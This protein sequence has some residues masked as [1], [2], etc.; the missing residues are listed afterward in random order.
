[1]GKTRAVPRREI[2]I[3]WFSPS[4]GIVQVV[5]PK[6]L[7]GG[8]VQ[9]TPAGSVAV[10]PWRMV[11]SLM[12]T[13]RAVS[14]P[15][16]VTVIVKTSDTDTIGQGI[17]EADA[18]SVTAISADGGLAAEAGADAVRDAARADAETT[19]SPFLN[20]RERRNSADLGSAAAARPA[21]A[22][23][24]VIVIHCLLE[25]SPRRVTGH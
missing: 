7:Y 24:S 21:S 9:E 13:L 5:V 25:S 3:T 10:T 11:A 17:T 8:V 19:A 20:A 15:W 1:L 12:A 2:F 23:R 18:L 22:L 14:G 4:D 16:F 6:V